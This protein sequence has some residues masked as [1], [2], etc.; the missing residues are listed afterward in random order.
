MTPRTRV[1]FPTGPLITTVSLGNV[2]GTEF[3]SHQAYR[4]CTS[5]FNRLP[6]P[7]CDLRSRVRFPTGPLITTV[8]LGNVAGTEFLSHQ[9]YRHCTSVFN[10][11]PNPLC[12]H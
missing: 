5:V 2:A 8:S 7:L 10:R 12:D 3:L 1:R 6:N 4:H 11:L 9:A